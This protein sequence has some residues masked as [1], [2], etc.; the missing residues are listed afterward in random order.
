MNY[1]GNTT[2]K[3]YFNI[4]K[5]ERQPRFLPRLRMS[6]NNGMNHLNICKSK[7]NID[8]LQGQKKRQT[9]ENQIEMIQN[10]KIMM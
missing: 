7:R 6:I 1:N 4:S 9:V 10:H 3:Q 5:N 2:Q 8:S